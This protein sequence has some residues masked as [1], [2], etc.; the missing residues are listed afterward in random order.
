[1]YPEIYALIKYRYI[2]GSDVVMYWSGTPNRYVITNFSKG[3]RDVV[4]QY[5]DKKKRPIKLQSQWWI[6]IYNVPY[7]DK[8]IWLKYDLSS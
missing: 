7:C 1:M 2:L 5:S 6:N 4:N 8:L 3:N